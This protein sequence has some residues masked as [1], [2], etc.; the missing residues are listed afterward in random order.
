MIAVKK[1]AVSMARLTLS[2]VLFCLLAA[3]SVNAEEQLIL[4]N[5]KEKENYTTGVYIVRALK[6]RKGEINLD[7]VIKGMKDEV[8]GESLLISE[9]E[10]RE[11]KAALESEIR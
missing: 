11:I 10:L 6:E 9:Y 8:T 3:A 7:I 5:Q 2:I 4:K 1:E